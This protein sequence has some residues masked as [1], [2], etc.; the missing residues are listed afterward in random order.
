MHGTQESAK[1]AP[2]TGALA[3]PAAGSRWMPPLPLQPRD[4][5]E[6]GE[7]EHDD[8]QRRRRSGSTRSLAEQR[9]ADAGERTTPISVKTTV[10]PAMKPTAP[11][12]DPAAGGGGRPVQ[13]VVEVGPGQSGHIGQIAGHERQDAR[14]QEADQPGERGDA[15]PRAA[16]ARSLAMPAKVSPTT[17]PALRGELG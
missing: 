13:R 9:P 2:S 14:R 6:E 8:E 5:P 7:P 12:S 10:N 17:Q 16:A 15:R 1:T 11:S 4:Q 3:S